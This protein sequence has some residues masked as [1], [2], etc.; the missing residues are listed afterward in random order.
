MNKITHLVILLVLFS[1]N[2]FAQSDSKMNE[3]SI[4][5]KIAPFKLLGPEMKLSLSIERRYKL[6][7]S[8]QI[9]GDYIFDIWQ[10]QDRSIPTSYINKGF[11]IIPEL[12]Y[13]YRN[14]NMSSGY[15][16]SNIMYKQLTR[17]YEEYRTET[18]G[19]GQPFLQL[20]PINLTKKVYAIHFLTGGLFYLDSSK[21]MAIDFNGGLGMRSRIVYSSV[22]LIDNGSVFFN[23]N[24]NTVTL[25]MICNLKFCY[26]IFK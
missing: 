8:I 3:P 4:L 5:V 7:F 21:R 26:S 22:P 12:R 14:A 10:A 13:Y 15:V 2:L 16:S 9:Q 6:P 25:G 24:S 11:R 17:T 18:D 19:S 1:T 20:T 23:S